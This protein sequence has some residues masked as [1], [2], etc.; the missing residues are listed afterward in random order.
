[1][2]RGASMALV[3]LARVHM[4]IYGAHVVPVAVE[5]D[6]AA[7]ENKKEGGKERIKKRGERSESVI[8]LHTSHLELSKLLF[9]FVL[10]IY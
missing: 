3:Q 7:Q 2:W 6:R 5:C 8:G 4:R 10:Y 1:M 9:C